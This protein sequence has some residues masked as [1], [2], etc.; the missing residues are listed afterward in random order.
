M[1]LHEGEKLD[2]V[3]EINNKL[4]SKNFKTEPE[5]RN[6]FTH[7]DQREV[8]TTWTREEIGKNVENFFMK[9]SFFRKFFFASLGV[10]ALALLYAGY[11]F[12]GGGNTVSNDNIDISII[13]NTFTAGGEELALQIQIKNKNNSAL[14]LV[15]LVVEYPNGSDESM[16]GMTRLRES[17]GTIPAGSTRN[18]LLKLVLFGQ[19][20]TSRQIRISLEYRV[21]GSNAI[22]VKEKLYD[23]SISSTPINLTIDA[24]TKV[25]PNQPIT[26][27]IK[28]T[29]N[30]TKP[31]EKILLKM[32]YPPGFQFTKATPAP[33]FGNNVWNFGDLAPGATRD[34]SITGRML[35]VSDGEEKTFHVSTGSQS[36]T[37][38]TAIGVVFSNFTH[39]L[40]IERP[41]VEAELIV[42]GSAQREYAIDNDT[43]L[44]AEI[45]WQNN[46]STKIN[47][48]ELHAKL[49]GNAIDRRSIDVDSGRYES[50]TDTIIWDAD[51]ARELAEVDPGDSGRVSFSLKTLPLYAEG[52]ILRDP[53]VRIE[54]SLSGRAEDSDA[55]ISNGDTKIV[56]VISDVNLDSK[57]LYFS[58]PFKNTGPIPPQA[59]KETT[60]TI[61]WSVTNT[62]SVI[63]RAKV[64][65]SLPPWIKFAGSTSPAGEDLTYNAG[66]KQVVWNIGSIPRGAG[67]TVVGKEVSFQVKLVPSLS[68]VGTTPLLLNAATLTGHD[69]FANVNVTAT[70]AAINT[71]LSSDPS[72]PPT[73]DKVVE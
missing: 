37:D 36:G 69:D 21:D 68:Q 60:Y 12:L 2:R 64:S 29:L 22:F 30:S 14:D 38:K 5:H 62:S 8:P 40:S 65:A 15:D 25:S 11:S 46:L 44:H 45:R 31:A 18:E 10:F 56:R 50:S 72:F 41:F 73:G 48:L 19:Q 51:S 47:N 52:N 35:D 26:L 23:V 13:G 28:T 39:T 17:L 7:P 53:L 20:G 67:L 43:P 58:G 9:T 16:E 61:V 49:S 55:N 4:F 70:K 59:E 57:A 32:D 3:E 27:N 66:S 54:T 33:S 63:S 42:N 71:R 34:V 6:I 24:P 1:H